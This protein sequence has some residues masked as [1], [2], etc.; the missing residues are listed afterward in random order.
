VITDEEL[1]SGLKYCRMRIGEMELVEMG[2]DG[3]RY[4]EKIFE[5]TMP[6]IDM[7]D[8]KGFED[9]KRLQATLEI[10][11]ERRWCR[12]QAPCCEC[13]YRAECRSSACT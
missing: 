7:S 12:A 1:N 6:F 5:L 9:G 4:D 10:S 13:H 11:F 8:E 2:I 3:E